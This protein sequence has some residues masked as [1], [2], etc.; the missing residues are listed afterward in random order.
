[1][2]TEVYIAPLREGS[3]PF[4]VDPNNFLKDVKIG[5]TI[6]F[7]EKGRPKDYFLVESINTSIFMDYLEHSVF[8]SKTR[9]EKTKKQIVVKRV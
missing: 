5:E 9:Y 1:M 8:L 2:T 6:T 4:Y 3:Q 7:N